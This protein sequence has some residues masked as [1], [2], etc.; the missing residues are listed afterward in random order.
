MVTSRSGVS[1]ITEKRHQVSPLESNAKNTTQPCQRS[2]L[3]IVLHS[4]F[5]SQAE[6]VRAYGFYE[7]ELSLDDL[8]CHKMDV[9]LYCSYALND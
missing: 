2:L 4:L 6:L 9:S 3:S 7:D 8:L 1:W 5:I